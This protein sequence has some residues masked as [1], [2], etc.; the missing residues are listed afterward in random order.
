M[1]GGRKNVLKRK[2]GG[3][4]IFLL[5]RISSGEEGKG[6]LNFVKKFKIKKMW[7]GKNI[8]LKDLLTP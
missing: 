4:I 5:G 2:R 6:D 8:K 3:N 1:P 7:T